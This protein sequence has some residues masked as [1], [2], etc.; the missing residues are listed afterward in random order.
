MYVLG[1]EVARM[2]R[3]AAARGDVADFVSTR[4]GYHEVSVLK[5]SQSRGATGSWRMWGREG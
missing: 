5:A 2:I 1:A 4:K 3:S